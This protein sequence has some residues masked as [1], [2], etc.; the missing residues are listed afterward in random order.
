M[1]NLKSAQILWQFWQFDTYD[2]NV[3]NLTVLS[4]NQMSCIKYLNGISSEICLG[5]KRKCAF[6]LHVQILIGE[7]NVTDHIHILTFD[8]PRNTHLYPLSSFVYKLFM[9]FNIIWG[10]SID[11]FQWYLVSFDIELFY[12]SERTK[13]ALTLSIILTR[14]SKLFWKKTLFKQL[15][16]QALPLSKC[17][18]YWH[19]AVIESC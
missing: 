17:D 12:N 3:L 19:T 13:M 5:R 15:N 4:F 16:E 18:C 2:G 10:F 14:H 1:I 7:T 11:T 8:K 6:T 9:S